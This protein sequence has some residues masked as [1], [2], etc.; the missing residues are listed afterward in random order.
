MEY[1]ILKLYQKESISEKLLDRFD[2]DTK[3]KSIVCL[4]VT[5]LAEIEILVTSLLFPQKL[6][7]LPGTIVFMVTVGACLRIIDADQRK[8]MDKYVDS[9]KKN[10]MILEKILITELGIATEAKVRE[11]IGIYQDF[12]NERT[13]E[14]QKR[15]K[16]ILTS[17]SALSGV[18]SISFVNMELIGIDFIRWLYMIAMPLF[19][20][21]TGVSFCLYFYGLFDSL[22][23]QYEM[24]IKDLNDLLLLKH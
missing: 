18:L 3:K 1:Y 5:I 16:I 7:Y 20:C 11:L 12:V 17:F 6:W 23:G 13:A 10:L 14:Q 24:M 9:H 4:I 19:F 21:V 22:K 2:S 15:N 8:H